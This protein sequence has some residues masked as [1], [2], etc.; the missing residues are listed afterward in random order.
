MKL[1]IALL[2]STYSYASFTILANV[3]IRF[4]NPEIRVDVAADGCANLN[5]TPDEILDMVDIAVSEYW[6]KISTSS[7][8]LRAGDIV[9][10]SSDYN[11]NMICDEDEPTCL[12]PVPNTNK[13]VLIVCNSNNNPFSSSGILAVTLP[14]NLN[15]AEI[16]GAVIGINAKATTKY[17]DQTRAQK[18]ALLAHEIGHAFGL[19][20]SSDT[21]SLMYFRNLSGRETIGVDDW[22]GATYLYPKE[23]APICGTVEKIDDEIREHPTAKTSAGLKAGLGVLLLSLIVGNI[24][25]NGILGKRNSKII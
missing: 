13:Q 2:I 19:G 8:H 24:L 4:A 16:V 20:H 22:Q 21:A 14:N 12:N 15:G 9:T 1:L 25:T 10:V 5:D 23:Q 18:I 6:N 3:P 11:N 17:N 7:L